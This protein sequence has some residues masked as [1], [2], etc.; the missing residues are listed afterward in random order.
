MPD[1]IVTISFS[2]LVWLSGIH[3]ILHLK[4]ACFNSMETDVI[5]DSTGAGRIIIIVSFGGIRP[6]CH[7]LLRHR[8]SG[9]VPPGVVCPRGEHER[10]VTRIEKVKIIICGMNDELVEEIA[11][12]P[13]YLTTSDW[14]RE[15]S[16]IIQPT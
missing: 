13:E 16:R 5:P 4:S 7:L 11:Q 2:S 12:V 9:S 6:C 10:F 1:V 3:G 15:M 8:D 14:L